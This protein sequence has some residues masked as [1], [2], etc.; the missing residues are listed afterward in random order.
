MKRLILLFSVQIF[1]VSCNHSERPKGVLE[2]KEMKAVLKDMHLTDAYLIT[3]PDSD[4]IRKVAPAY[5]Q[6]LFK[7]HHTDL[8]IFE[9]SLRYYAQH[10]VLLD[11]LYTQLGD[12]LSRAQKKSHSG[13]KK[14]LKREE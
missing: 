5:Y 11:S 2:E 8:K 10:P 7:K 4:S 13:L 1:L 6:M 14:P 3:L 12:E 9:K